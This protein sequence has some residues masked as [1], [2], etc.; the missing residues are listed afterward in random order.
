MFG[1]LFFADGDVLLLFIDTLVANLLELGF[2]VD[3]VL[4]SVFL[5]TEAAWTFFALRSFF[6]GFITE[7]LDFSGLF[8]FSLFFVRCTPLKR[9]ISADLEAGG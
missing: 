4:L 9:A 1:P 2:F 7:S 8:D 3:T 5:T 6:V